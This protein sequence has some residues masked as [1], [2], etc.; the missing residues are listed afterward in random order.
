M[1]AKEK[2][3]AETSVCFGVDWAT[4]TPDGVMLV[5]FSGA[6][7]KGNRPIHWAAMHSSPE[8]IAAL[9]DATAEAD[10]DVES[11]ENNNGETPMM[12]AVRRDNAKVAESVIKASFKVFG[13]CLDLIEGQVD[14]TGTSI[15]WVAENVQSAEVAYVCAKGVVNPKD[16]K[17]TEFGE[18]HPRYLPCEY[19]TPLQWAVSVSNVAAVSGFI[20]AWGADAG[21]YMKN[22]EF[23]YR[24]SIIHFA[25][26]REASIATMKVLIGAGVDVNY[27]DESGKTALDYVL[28]QKSKEYL[29]EELKKAGGYTTGED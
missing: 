8:V 15:F 3:G 2:V 19:Y 11:R 16:K 10:A 5:D 13:I 6:D 25:V 28:S 26:W 29:V 12:I 4:V 21:L 1:V 7:D 20:R 18:L 17:I 14:L 24:E 23:G 9:A 27:L 22:E